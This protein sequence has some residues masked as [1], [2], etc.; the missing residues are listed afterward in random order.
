MTDRAEQHWYLA[1]ISH[2]QGLFKC[3]PAKY[4]TV[5]AVDLARRLGWT[6][7]S[8]SEGSITSSW[9]HAWAIIIMI[10]SLLLLIDLCQYT[11][12]YIWFSQ[13]KASEY[14]PALSWIS[15][16]GGQGPNQYHA[17]VRT[18]CKTVWGGSHLLCMMYDSWMN[19]LLMCLCN[20]ISMIVACTFSTST[21]FSWKTRICSWDRHW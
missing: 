13:L 6:M 17:F 14:G 2:P 8:D 19:I 21:I 15:M 1:I 16:W 18:T 12:L 3:P 20:P 5:F 7:L 9:V 11:N 10:I 4:N